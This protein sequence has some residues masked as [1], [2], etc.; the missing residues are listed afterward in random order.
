LLV[1]RGAPGNNE[2]GDFL[3]KSCGNGAAIDDPQTCFA[4]VLGV[5]LIL[6]AVEAL[7]LYAVHWSARQVALA[8]SAKL[9]T[10][11]HAQSLMLGPGGSWTA[12]GSSPAELFCDKIETVRQGLATW[13]QT[14]PLDALLVIALVGLA[15]KMHF[16]LTLAVVLLV[17]AC[18]PLLHRLRENAEAREALFA[19]RAAKQRSL[20]A[21]NLGQ[22][23][24]VDGAP[25]GAQNGAA[26][27]EQLAHHQRLASQQETVA[28]RA[29][30][31]DV[32][33]RLACVTFILFLVGLNVLREPSRITPAE[34]IVMVVALA[35]AYLPIKR[36]L[37]LSS[38]LDDAERAAAELGEFLDRGPAV[39]TA[40]A[41][42]ELGRLAQRVELANVTVTDRSGHKLLDS[43]SLALPAGSFTAIVSTDPGLPEALTELLP[44]YHDPVSGRILIDGTDIRTVTFDSLR[45]QVA[46]VLAGDWLNTA[47][48][49]ENIGGE[50]YSA[51]DIADAAR[52][53]GAYDF[54]QRLPQGFDTVI[55]EH[56]IR[57][58]P[59]EVFR[60][61]VAHALLRKPSLVVLDEPV[62]DPENLSDHPLDDAI[63]AISEGRTV[64][65]VARRMSTL[66]HAPRVLLFH[67]GK[68]H[69]DATH[70]E[71]LQKV[72][73][74]RH[75]NYVRF[76]EFRGVV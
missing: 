62:E 5:W 9:R 24:W 69:A 57:I 11:L 48:V 22:A 31:V 23:R 17:G 34:T 27:R 37:R 61:S 56:G 7:A 38:E 32:F 15:L 65:A 30:P 63:A 16:W 6:A 25:A 29:E 50:R 13:W 74:Y 52:R 33:L 4:S 10:A 49:S 66:R 75:L 8:G 39:H 35:V 68:L 73:L 76:N 12:R 41:A 44:R 14:L 58:S 54:I 26:F 21:E 42:K 20:L 59:D 64:V 67:E 43:V 53:A 45:G 28:S 40:P 36:L 46:L 60:L 55:G 1:T 72:D 47:S 51:E 19:D 18:W 70:A 71:L 2:F 3:R